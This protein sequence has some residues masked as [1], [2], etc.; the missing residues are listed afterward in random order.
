[1]QSGDIVGDVKWLKFR[2]PDAFI[3]G[4]LHN[5]GSVWDEIA[6]ETPSM[7]HKEVLNW[8]HNKVSIFPYFKHFKGT[9]KG[10]DYDSD[11]PPARQFQ[12]N[13]SCRPFTQFVQRTLLNRLE[14]GAITLL[15]RVGHVTPPFLVLPLTVEPTK[16]RLCHDAR[17]L[18]LWM[19]DTPF[20]LDGLGDLPRYVHKDSYQTILDDKSGYDH[21]LL[22]K[23][24]RTFFGIQWGGWYFTYNTLP[25][26]WKVSPYVYHTTGLMASNFFRSIG[27]PCLLYIDDRHNGQLQVSLSKGEYLMLNSE[28]ERNRASAASAI[29]LVAYYLVRLGYFLGL[30]KSVLSPQ[31]RVKYLGYL[32]DSS[33]QAFHCVPE[34]QAK[35]INLIRDILGRP[36]VTVKT[37]QRLAGKCISFS[38]AFPA[39]RLFTREINVAIAR[40]QKSMKPIAVRGA[41]RDEVSHWLFLEGWD[42]PVPWRDER[43]Y[44]VSVATDASGYGWGGLII[45]PITVQTSDYWTKEEMDWDISTK[46][47]FAVERLLSACSDTLRNAR[48]DAQV[49]NQSVINAWNNQ[50]C[51]SVQL[52][53][54][55]KKLFFTTSEHNMSL[56]LCYV[57]TNLNPADL[58]SRRLSSMDSKLTD[59]TWRMVQ[60][61]FGGKEGHSCDL[62]ALDSNVMTD[63]RGERLPHFSPY[64]SPGSLGTNLFAQDLSMHSSILSRPYVFPPLVL[65]GP[66]LRFLESYRQS[67]TVL[68]LDVY[69]RKYWWPLLQHK[70][71]RS[72]K[73]ARKGDSN[74]LLVP[75]KEGWIPY[76]N[77]PGDLWAFDIVF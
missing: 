21:I 27:I 34:K 47:A 53:N 29:F 75:S 45:S 60:E 57:P 32:V 68:V 19:R 5:H 22:T 54:A 42:S 30:A 14:T 9:F 44:R 28:D 69:P 36:T 71:M 33:T 31:K 3:A 37:L 12:N 73:L 64:P 1:M 18:N 51:K 11:R 50:G 59:S 7:K 72:C 25:F 63:R 48:V 38:L 6:G 13:V 74:A 65:V 46:E 56:H 55:L 23:E 61:V 17:Y 8:I 52:N 16:P 70:A 2:D 41:L 77:I 39:A 20:S 15:G 26:G 43:H 67:C 10:K 40:G 76:G 49:D 35:F 24:S 62:M 66:V 58:P 4:E